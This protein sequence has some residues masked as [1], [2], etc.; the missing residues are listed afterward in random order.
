[1]DNTYI[2]YSTEDFACDEAFIDWVTVG[3][4]DESW[5][6]WVTKNTSK[7]R[8]V[9]E[10]KELVLELQNTKEYPITK[11]KKSS[12]WDNISYRITK[13]RH[14]NIRR[15]M[16]SVTAVAACI[17]LV[18]IVM[19]F[20]K[21]EKKNESEMVINNTAETS[22]YV[23]PDN[24]YIYLD[25]KSSI[26]FDKNSFNE[27]RTL[28]LKGQAFFDVEKGNQFIVKSQHGEVKVLGTSFNVV[29][30]ADNFVVTCYTGKV[31]VNYMGKSVLLLPNEKSDFKQP[32]NKVFIDLKD[33]MPLWVGGI[34]KFENANLAEVIKEV[35]NIYKIDILIHDSI[36][37]GQKYT[38]AIVKNDIEKAMISLTWPLH[39]TYS[40]EGDQITVEKNNK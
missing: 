10:A 40:M 21:S 5:R 24:S 12:V 28:K 25:S 15:L 17:T 14:S 36:L 19:P 1:M 35:E 31:A 33:E 11:E 2:N 3:S 32:A 8:E 9:Q 37:N 38:G 27:N 22:E 16:F 6:D 30:E 39:L 34:V 7:Q 29:E 13:R 23:L 4:N 20:N 26:V 18:L